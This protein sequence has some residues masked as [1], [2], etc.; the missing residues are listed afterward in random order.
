MDFYEER[1]TPNHSASLYMTDADSL[2]KFENDF[3]AATVLIDSAL[4]L[5]EA[6]LLS[7]SVNVD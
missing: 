5:V 2:M 3:R 6:D 4:I 7:T 1:M